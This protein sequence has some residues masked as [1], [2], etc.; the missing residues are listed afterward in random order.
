MKTKEALG[1]KNYLDSVATDC[2]GKLGY[3][4]ARNIRLLNTELTEYNDKRNELI[5]KYGTEKDGNI[6]IA[7]GTEEHKKFV[8]EM[9]QYDDIELEVE[10][11]KVNEDVLSNSNLSANSM[12]VLMDFMVE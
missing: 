7:I 4:V 11:M 12:L 3:A 6:S 2:T 9:A 1:I 5:R 8:E 10:L